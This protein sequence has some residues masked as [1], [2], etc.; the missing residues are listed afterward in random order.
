MTAPAHYVVSW[1]A[2]AVLL[3]SAA[4]YAAS[5]TL[6]RPP[7]GD[8]DPVPEYGHAT[9]PTI[10]S[11]SKLEWTAPDCLAWKDSRYKFVIATA[12]RIE[13]SD[14]AAVRSRMGAIS[15]TRGLLYWSVTEGAW[16]VLIKDA[17]ALSSANGE[18]RADFDAAELR[19]DATLHFVEQD[20][21]SDEPVVYAMHVLESKPGRIVVETE[22]VTPIKAMFTTPFPPGTL[23]TAYIAK[24][25]DS[26]M[27]GLYVIS[28]ATDRASGLVSLAK[29][30]YENRA[31]ALFAHFAGVAIDHGKPPR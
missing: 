22:N 30:S 21:R 26:H 3:A 27:W 4:T 29:S 7:C 24:R 19:E 16:R 15:T 31:K 6:P 14:A 20:N 28:A 13:A 2:A 5:A 23:K 8:G 12:G 25:L 17:S 18:R 11:W 10:E 1:A 9:D